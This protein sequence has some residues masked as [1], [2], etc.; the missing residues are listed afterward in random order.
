[1]DD[2]LPPP[3][4]TLPEDAPA[5]A[6]AAPEAEADLEPARDVPA[7]KAEPAPRSGGAAKTGNTAKSVVRVDFDRIE[8]LVNPVEAGLSPHSDAMNGLEEFQRLTRDIQD[9]VMMIRAQ[10]VK[11]FFQRMSRI[12]RK[13]SSAVKKDVRLITDI[14]PRG[15]P[16][17]PSLAMAASR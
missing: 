9:S 7:A 5:L 3:P 6:E 11:S 14:A 8:R 17:L 10:P 15:L 1:M 16:R 13:G 2:D 4:P 12:V